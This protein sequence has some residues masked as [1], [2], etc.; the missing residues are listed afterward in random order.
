MAGNKDGIEGA[1]K[2]LESG[3]NGSVSEA[4]NQSDLKAGCAGCDKLKAGICPLFEALAAE[5]GAPRADILTA[6][7]N[8]PAK[9]DQG[10]EARTFDSKMA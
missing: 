5:T 1:R 3:W 7:A 9:D 4:V 2:S 8:K 6:V 10:A